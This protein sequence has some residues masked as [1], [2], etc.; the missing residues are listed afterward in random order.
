MSNK[1]PVTVE[2]S[3]ETVKKIQQIQ[4]LTGATA[5]GVEI[6]LTELYEK[7][8]NDI[9]SAASD[10]VYNHIRGIKPPQMVRTSG[11][12]V[13]SNMPKSQPT[14]NT[15]DSFAIT[16]DNEIAEALGDIEPEE[17]KAEENEEATLPEYGGLTE[18]ILQADMEVEDPKTEAK[19]EALPDPIADDNSFAEAVGID[20]KTKFKATPIAP[21]HHDEFVDPRAQRRKKVLAPRKAKVSYFDGNERPPSAELG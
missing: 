19:A 21:L 17:P 20:T 1:I 15:V 11:Y 5:E 2:I 3:P 9:I 18:E 12:S 7:A 8:I 10:A 13:A 16:D 4:I 6:L 14:V